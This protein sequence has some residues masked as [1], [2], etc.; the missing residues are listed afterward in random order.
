MKIQ[1]EYWFV[2]IS[3]L[4]SGFIVFM[5]RIFGNLGLSVYEICTLAYLVT[6][7]AILPFIFFNRENW[8]K[9]NLIWLI[10]AY[11]SVSIV[12]I[13]SQYSAVMIGTP[14]AIVVL[15]L[16]TQPLWTTFIS[17]LF[18]KEKISRVNIISCILVLVGIVFLVNPF[19]SLHNISLAG[20]IISLVGGMG[21]SGWIIFGSILS[22][23]GNSPV[24]SLFSTMVATVLFALITQPIAA[25]L[26]H[27]PE[28]T[29]LSLN[30]STEVWLIIIAFGL[31]TQLANHLFYLNGVKKVRA[32]DAGI[33]MLLEP[34]IGAIL[35]ALFLQQPLTLGII[36]G[37]ALILL[38]NYYTIRSASKK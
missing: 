25:K 23:K 1:K 4:I 2:I 5:G 37:G 15:L 24:N 29:N 3:G 10:L 17:W 27:R 20:I 21:L 9:K 13:F 7:I 30:H 33:I 19:G 16:Y 32:V 34:I 18:L 31:T 11:C 36:L 26:I 35:A 28:I 14:I 8:F 22:K 12:T 38:A 6:V